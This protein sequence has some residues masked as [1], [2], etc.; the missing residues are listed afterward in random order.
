MVVVVVVGGGGGGEGEGWGG[1]GGGGV[2]EEEKEERKK[3]R[4]VQG[5]KE[6]RNYKKGERNEKIRP[7]KGRKKYAMD[8]MGEKWR[9]RVGN[10]GVRKK[11]I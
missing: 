10:R 3:E 11:R 2:I 6:P 4:S 5:T 8:R 9:E 7:W 1:K